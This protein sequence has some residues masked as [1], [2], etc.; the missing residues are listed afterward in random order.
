M[1]TLVEVGDDHELARGH[2]VAGHCS[3]DW[4][5]ARLSDPRETM[6]SAEWVV[7]ARLRF[8]G[9]QDHVIT[10]GL[11]LPDGTPI[12]LHGRALFHR[13]GAP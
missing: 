4:L 6:R 1:E 5:H 3:G 10:R 7:S 2:S 9:L 12:D 13:A 11:R 8:G